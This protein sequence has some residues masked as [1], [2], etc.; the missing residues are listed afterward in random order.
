MIH[1]TP[2]EIHDHAY[3]FRPS[4]HVV[5][6][7]EC[8]R[9]ADAVTAER[10]ALKDALR[11]G[12]PEVPADLLVRLERV[13]APGR[14]FGA[15]ALATAALLLAALTWTLFQPK[16]PPG[17]QPPAA[18]STPEEDLQK[19]VGYLNSPSA[20][21]QELARTAL[22]KYG[23]IAIPA[24][25]R[26]NADPILIDECRGFNDADRDAYRKAQT[27]RLTVQWQ[28]VP[29]I[30]AVD[31]LREAS[32]LSFHISNVPNADTFPVTLDLGNATVLEILDRLSLITKFPWGRSAALD[33]R[34]APYRPRNYTPIFYFGTE[35]PAPASSAP[36]RVPSD[37]PWIASLLRD[38]D[39]L[40]PEEVRRRIRDLIPCIHDGLW[41]LLD[42]SRPEVRQL[43]ADALRQAYGPPAE[44]ARSP[45]VVE[46]DERKML[47]DKENTPFPDILVSMF[48]SK[49]TAVV[50]DPRIPI[51]RRPSTYKVKDLS[52]KNSL[53]L[54]IAQFSLDYFVF[55]R[56]V[57]V[58]TP[59]LS[60]YRQRSPQPLWVAP[61]DAKRID[62]WIADL[63][64]A[65]P[66]RQG[67]ARDA[68][69]AGGR[70]GLDW[71]VHAS[72][73]TA[74]PLS[75]RF[76]ETFRSV[77]E[78][79]G[80]RLADQPAAAEGQSL[81]PAQNAI[82]ARPLALRSADKTLETLL[83]ENGVKARFDSP[84]PG[85]V[86]V[87]GGDLPVDALLRAVL[88]PLGLDYFMD[89]DTV[90]VD[91]AAKARAAVERK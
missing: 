79:L 32:G 19:L 38:P 21:K 90:V 37:Q 5:S 74:P 26:A 9:A 6:C 1:A 13:K 46:L 3:G 50:L 16:T 43:A 82:R 14:R 65:D 34:Y 42:S 84:D 12:A 63:A 22:R 24:L 89:G 48:P 87:A 75:N 86:V 73:A 45:L 31:H 39:S 44:P 72:I 7:A 78:E 58:T 17:T 55:D 25:E 35:T 52:L 64:S 10:E 57:L 2:Q 54:L 69:K 70:S 81:T 28:D 40:S 66:S 91:T 85:P 68:A 15:P 47:I 49:G 76:L 83:K 23:G 67:R 29:L 88:H 62:A 71:L 41:L 4:D 8:R 80:I 59:D 20:L 27:T 33:P 77:A 61:D 60:P 51:D 36:V 30:D 56:W 11:E 18:P 53:K